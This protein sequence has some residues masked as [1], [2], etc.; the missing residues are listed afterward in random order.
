MRVSIV[1]AGFV[2][3]DRRETPSVAVVGGWHRSDSCDYSCTTAFTQ[4]GLETAPSTAIAN[5]FKPP[6][7]AS[8]LSD[9]EEAVAAR[10][11]AAIAEYILTRKV[12]VRPAFEDHEANQVGDRECRELSVFRCVHSNPASRRAELCDDCAARDFRSVCPGE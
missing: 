6:S 12:L 11:L 5:A 4:V 3:R 2:A 7:P 1:Y 10:S 9:A 8:Q